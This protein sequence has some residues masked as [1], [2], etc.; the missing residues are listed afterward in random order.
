MGRMPACT[1][2]EE[3]GVVGVEGG[4]LAAQLSPSCLASTRN[5]GRGEC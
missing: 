4:G 5:G 3:E 2:E 1:L